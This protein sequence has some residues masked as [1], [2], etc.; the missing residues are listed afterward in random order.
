MS[1]F[2]FITF[3]IESVS[4]ISNMNLIILTEMD[5]SKDGK[6]IISD[7]RAKHIIEIL[8]SN[9]GDTVEVG[10]LNGKIG[11]AVIERITFSEIILYPEEIKKAPEIKPD[12]TLICALPR[13]QTVKKI[14]R[15]TATMGVKEIHFIRA[16]RVE[17]SFYHSPLLQKGN[18]TPFLI[19]GL[20]QGKL[21]RL[22]E[23]TIH[24][25]FKPF[26]EDYLPNMIDPNTIKLLPEPDVTS[27][28]SKE[29]IPD[30]SSI[31]VAIGPE[32]G[33]VPFETELMRNIGFKS[34]C[35]SHSILRVE[36]AVI[37]T[38]S[39]I[40]LIQNENYP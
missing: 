36:Q 11:R 15:A 7:H 12:I 5:S 14:L 10:F 39:Q 16:N 21:T 30:I 28:L 18:Y 35:L 32:G 26:I 13:P 8:K 34:F 20:S 6:Y 3:N 33:W 2:E 1:P 40:E 19:E 25:R 38:L 22:P 27:Y 31:V 37:A 29:L 9:Q 24:Q 17:K 23:V 4:Y